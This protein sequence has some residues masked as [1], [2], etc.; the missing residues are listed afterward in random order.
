MAIQT[1]NSEKNTPKK[2]AIL[3]KLKYNFVTD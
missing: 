3:L 1:L 2:S